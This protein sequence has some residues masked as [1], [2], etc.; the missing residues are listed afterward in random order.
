MPPQ[1]EWPQKRR[2][3]G[4]KVPRIDGPAKALGTAKYSF[5][6]NRKG[7]QYAVILRSPHAHARV[8]AI[9]TSGAEKSPGFAGKF[10][11][12]KFKDPTKP[13]PVEV[14]YAGEEILAIAADTEEHARDA[15]RAV[16]IDYEILEHIV[17][18]DIALKHPEKGTLANAAEG[19]VR[20][21]NNRS[22]G[23]VEEAFAAADAVVEGIYH[24]PV[25]THVCLESHGLV[26]EWDGDNLTVWC[27]TQAVPGVADGLAAYFRS[28]GVPGVKARCITHHMGGG[29]GSKF[30]AGVEGQMACE[31]ARLVKAPVKLFLDRAEEHTT[32]GNRPSATAVVKIA[33]TKDGKLTAMTAECHG[34]PGGGAG[35][36]ASDAYHALLPYVYPI[37][38]VRLSNRTVRLNHGDRRA[39]RAPGHPQACYITESAVDD[40]CNKLGLDP[41]MVRRKNL[42]DERDA[43]RPIYEREIDLIAEMCD[44]KK[45]WHPPGKGPARGP[46]KHGMGFA[47]HT[48]GGAGRGDNDVRVTIASDGSVGVTCSTQDLGTGARTV[49]GIIAAE[50]LGLEVKQINVEIGESQFGRSTGSGGSTTTPGI[51]PAVL[52]A[53]CNA[54]DALFAK[55]APRLQVKPED[56]VIDP[57]RPGKIATKDGA[58]IWEWKEACARL[59]MDRVSEAGNWSPRLTGSGVGGCQVAEVWVDTETGVVRCTKIY[60]VQDCGLL[61]NLQGCESQ[62]AGGVI[63]GVNYALFEEMIMDQ[64]TGRMVNPD[65]EFYKLGGIRD[66]PE[67]VVK[68][69][70]MPERGVIGIGEPPTISTAAAIGNAICNA[71]GVRVGS[72][73]FTPDKVLAAL[74]KG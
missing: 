12:K 36:A 63:M 48:W 66:M 34:T 62:V 55:I 28:N 8:K 50:V 61:V 65:L 37:P 68:M 58:K 54:R 71:I 56:L 64:A 14:Y 51:S 23:K 49:L 70:D 39:M 1:T 46:V 45:K 53:A 19:N 26:A 7:M 42:P 67:I 35:A 13:L 20:A 3:M 72:T 59:G 4:T 6:I 73:P 29:Y 41:L 10:V 15:A 18:E 33:G 24:L 40:L 74:A 47:L 30:A 9:D 21:P 27:S 22:T 25:Q 16:R 2:L 43:R 57:A 32:A 52:N 38:N 31:L 11:L 5:D 44:W 17:H 69:L 60:A